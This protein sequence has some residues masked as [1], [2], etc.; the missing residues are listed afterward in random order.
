M[1]K[2]SSASEF[3]NKTRKESK[4][5]MTQKNSITLVV[6]EINIVHKDKQESKSIKLTSKMKVLEIFHTLQ[7]FMLF[8][9]I[10][11]FLHKR[12]P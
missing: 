8:L 5:E 4:K 10:T 9:S 7:L 2:I 3:P 6:Q 12:I 11:R 1:H